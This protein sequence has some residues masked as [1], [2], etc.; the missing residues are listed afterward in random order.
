[1][2]FLRDPA[3][4]REWPLRGKITLIGRDPSCDVVI[5]TDRT[6]WR[7][8]LIVHSNQGYAIED[9]DSVNGTFV[10]GRRIQTRTLLRSLDRLDISGLTA[11]FHDDGGAT[12]APS[13]AALPIRQ[14]AP[15]AQGGTAPSNAESEEPASILTSLDV[16]NGGR[17]E[18]RPETKLQTVL[19]ISKVLGNWGRFDDAM[20]R[21]LDSLF[22]I[23]PHAD[24]GFILL[25][26]DET[27][28]LLCKASRAR[29]PLE[30]VGPAVSQ[31]ILNHVLTTGRAVLSADAG[32]DERFDPAQSIQRYRIGSILCVP[33][34]G[35]DG[36]RLGVLQIDT[37]DKRHPFCEEDLEV[38][39]SA[40]T[41]T[42]RAIELSELH[43]EQNDLEAAQRIQKS[44]LPPAPPVVEGLRFFD[45][46]AAA[47]RIG[48]DY[49]DY[50]PL[51]GQRLAVAIGDVSGKGAPAA[52]LMARLSAAARFCLATE[53]TLTQAVS[54]INT[55]LAQLEPDRFI[56][57]LVLVLDLADSS[58][59]VVNAGHP[60]LLRRLG[61][62][63]R[64]DEVGDAAIGL[65]L[66]VFDRPYEETRMTL[67][68]GDVLVLY[69][70]GITEARNPRGDFFGL[71][72]LTSIVQTGPEE[73]D[74]LGQAIL[75]E[76]RHFAGN[77]PQ[78]DD[79]TLV[80]L[81]RLKE[82]RKT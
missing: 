21:I 10:N 39:I 11:I 19:E 65:P 68:P 42:A 28:Q 27:G 30:D 49:Y 9:L 18:V 26:D 63:K 22:T 81:T 34:I 13:P 57:F 5:G 12:P 58:L 4:T 3:T 55:T 8:A 79:L 7:H 53:S 40:S 25:R 16:S 24:R 46:Y 77:R 75:K 23:F 51:P 56:T 70:D 33:M 59:T 43:R 62:D 66:G 64:V 73:V 29:P 44:F 52:L 76:V 1:M 6:S 37:R 14:P 50:I 60:P 61:L 2:A 36:A 38:L 78:S 45:Y 32:H 82:V 71:E 31:S 80:C 72:R 17:L 54:R 67:E 69:T 47:R 15:T 20:P 41:Q 35:Q 48:G 74:A